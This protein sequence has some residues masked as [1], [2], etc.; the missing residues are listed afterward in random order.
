MTNEYYSQIMGLYFSVHESTIKGHIQG[1]IQ[2]QRRGQGQI[3]S[4][5]FVFCLLGQVLSP[6]QYVRYIGLKLI[7]VYAPSTSILTQIL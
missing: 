6:L 7:I 4:E 2:G 1:Q 3:N 5:Q